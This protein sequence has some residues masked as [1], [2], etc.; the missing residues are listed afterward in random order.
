MYLRQ[1]TIDFFVCGV[2]ITELHAR[3]G[4]RASFRRLLLKDSWPT[5]GVYFWKVFVDKIVNQRPVIH[6]K[7]F[8]ILGYKL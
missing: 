7:H 4:D 1:V 2:H 3:G 5:E 8:S 6:C